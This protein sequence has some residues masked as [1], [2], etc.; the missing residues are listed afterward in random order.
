MK[1]SKQAYAVGF[2]DDI[3]MY[4]NHGWTAGLVFYVNEYDAK[5]A[6]SGKVISY[7]LCRVNEKTK[8][9]GE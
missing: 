9:I 6:V 4:L 2:D 7:K 8:L 3:R 1:N 5:I